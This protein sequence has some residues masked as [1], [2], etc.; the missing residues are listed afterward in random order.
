MAT[1][2]LQ[3]HRYVGL[4]AQRLQ[5]EKLSENNLWERSDYRHLRTIQ[6]IGAVIALIIIAE[7]GNLTGFYHHRQYLNFFGFNLSASQSGQKHSGYR[8]SKRGNSRLRYAFWFTATVAVRRRENSFRYKYER[9]I[10]ENGDKPVQKRKAMTAIATKVVRVA[11]E[12]VK[13]DIDYK[14]LNEISHGA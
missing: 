1:F 3:L 10:W 7:S 9:Y 13:Q 14:E 2:R 12:I 11:H 5:L 4:A 6:G 8:L